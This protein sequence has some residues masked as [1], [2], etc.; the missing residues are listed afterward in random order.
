MISILKSHTSCLP[1]IV[2]K[3]FEKDRQFVGEHVDICGRWDAD[4]LCVRTLLAQGNPRIPFEWKHMFCHTSAQAIC[5]SIHYTYFQFGI[6][7]MCNPSG[8]FVRRC[9]HCGLKLELRPLHTL[10]MTAFHLSISGCEGEN[11]FGILACLL[12]LL[13]LGVDPL[14]TANI[15]LPALL[16][17]EGLSEC[18]HQEFDPCQFAGELQHWLPSNCTEEITVGWTIISCVL[19]EVRKVAEYE[20]PDPEVDYSNK[21]SGSDRE[22]QARGR[23]PEPVEY[24]YDIKLS[25]GACESYGGDGYFIRSN[26]LGPLW[27]AVQTELLTYRR[28]EEGDPWTS[29]HFD[30]KTLS[31]DLVN[32]HKIRFGLLRDS[33]I[34]PFCR[35]GTIDEIPFPFLTTQ[36]VSAYYFSN[37]DDWNRS[38]FIT[39]D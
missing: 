6:K 35:C 16:M 37:M 28:L 5:H 21:S 27:A 29:P 26:V 23:E 8:L 22:S 9:S 18:S 31:E 33:M 19:G 11:L 4:S 3:V 25:C 30:M 24:R 10:L 34:K 14:T 17:D 2:D 36:D 15:S 32:G 13:Q 38:T 20:S 1:V 12:C 39:N 7:I